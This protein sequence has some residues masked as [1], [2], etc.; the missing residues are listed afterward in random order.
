MDSKVGC[1]GAHP[2]L[3]FFEP[4][5]IVRPNLASIR[6]TSAG[7]SAQLSASAF[8]R[9]DQ[10]ANSPGNRA[11]SYVELAVSSRRWLKPSPVLI[12]STHRRT[13]R[14]SWPGLLANIPMR[15]ARLKT[16]T[17]GRVDLSAN[18]PIDIYLIYLIFLS[19]KN[20]ISTEK[21]EKIVKGD[22]SQYHID[23]Q[24]M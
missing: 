8:N 15:F 2:L 7:W 14:L 19:C 20:I 13:A 11:H 16:V 4:V 18:G 22:T 21:R 6:L 3:R 10:Y 24:A 5:R 12:S 9:L 23:I 17:V 1:A